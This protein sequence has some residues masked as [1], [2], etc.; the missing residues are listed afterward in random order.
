MFAVAQV[1]QGRT[2][3]TLM[4]PRAAVIEDANTNSFRVFVI[5]RDNRARLRV[6]LLAPRQSGDTVRLVSGVKEGE[7]VAT[8]SLNQLYDSAPV[9]HAE[10]R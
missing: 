9:T 1:D 8:T 10:T 7:R 5:D 3:R 6:V 4:V 2:V